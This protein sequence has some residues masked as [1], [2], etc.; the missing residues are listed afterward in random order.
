MTKHS[1][2]ENAGRKLIDERIRKDIIPVRKKDLLPT[3][4]E[5]VKQ[6]N[7]STDTPE[8]YIEHTVWKSTNWKGFSQWFPWTTGS[9]FLFVGLVVL[10]NPADRHYSPLFFLMALALFLTSIPLK[11]MAK[12]VVRLG[13]DWSHNIFWMKKASSKDIVWEADANLIVSFN[14]T[15]Y[16]SPPRGTFYTGSAYFPVLRGE[17]VFALTYMRS[18]SPHPCI[19]FQF[20][21]ATAGECS[22]VCKKVNHLLENQ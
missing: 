9:F 6:S 13:F 20:V 21:F 4:K 18:G 15:P 11:R 14:F 3:D 22:A 17:K 10:G 1:N 12:T 19:L 2:A 5:N 7:V 16:T 8:Q